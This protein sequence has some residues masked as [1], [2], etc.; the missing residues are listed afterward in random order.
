MPPNTHTPELLPGSEGVWIG[1]RKLV[2]LAQN[3]LAQ[4]Q[5]SPWPGILSLLLENEPLRGD[6]GMFSFSFHQGVENTP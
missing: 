4:S 2:L 6:K 5:T 1:G 3:Q